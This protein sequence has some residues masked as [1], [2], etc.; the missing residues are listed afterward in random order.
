MINLPLRFW[1]KDDE[2]PTPVIIRNLKTCLW[3]HLRNIISVVSKI[4]YKVKI[5]TFCWWFSELWNWSFSNKQYIG[6]LFWK[7]K[8]CLQFEVRTEW[9]IVF[10][11]YEI[12]FKFHFCIFASSRT[13]SIVC[14][15]E[16]SFFFWPSTFTQTFH[17]SWNIFHCPFIPKINSF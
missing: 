16:N 13:N 15:W 3:Y 5:Q 6:N 1:K 11:S 14:L 9:I 8:L 2:R 10:L 7:S 17:W 4:I 12:N